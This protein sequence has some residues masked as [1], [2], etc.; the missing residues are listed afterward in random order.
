MKIAK[1]KLIY[2]LYILFKPIFI[3]GGIGNF[4]SNNNA[5]RKWCLNRAEQSKNTSKLMEKAGISKASQ[6]HSCLRPSKILQSGKA[7]CEIMR[8]LMEE[9]TNPF[10]VLIDKDKLLNLRSGVALHS[11]NILNCRDIGEEKYKTFTR[12]CIE[13]NLKSFHDPIKFEM[14]KDAGKVTRNGKT[15]VIEVNRNVIG[16]L[17]AISTKFE[18]NIDFEVALAYPLTSVPLSLSNPDGSQSVT[19]KNKLVEVLSQYQDKHETQQLEITDAQVYA[20]DFIAQLRVIA[21]E[22]PETYEQL[23][24]K[25]LQ[26]IPKGYL[27]VDLVADTYPLLVS[28]QLKETKEEVHQR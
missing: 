8:V 12:E 6:S 15:A 23:A 3:T 16:K 9:Y 17:L 11:D 5:V 10:D 22:I 7:V 14:F 24:I 13:G 20:I 4:A 18:K 27:R 28:N 19:Q 26:S 2:T 25:V 1:G 21:K